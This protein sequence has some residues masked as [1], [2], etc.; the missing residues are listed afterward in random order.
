MKTTKYVKEL[1]ENFI[2]IS[3]QQE[4]AII[5][6]IDYYNNRLIKEKLGFMS[7]VEYRLKNEQNVKFNQ[8]P[9]SIEKGT[10]NKN[11]VSSYVCR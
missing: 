9:F 11:Y 8:A 7:P 2:R 4:K 5:E 1:K 6:Y 3:E 10:I